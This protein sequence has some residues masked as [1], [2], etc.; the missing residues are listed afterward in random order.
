MLVVS[1]EVNGPE[2]RDPVKRV[3]WADSAEVEKTAWGRIAPVTREIEDELLDEPPVEALNWEIALPKARC[4]AWWLV[5]TW[6]ELT[7]KDE[8]PPVLADCK[9][10][11]AE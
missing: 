1:V 4:S 6:I 2:G 11:V 7:I 9:R 8:V 5:C 10:T 3:P